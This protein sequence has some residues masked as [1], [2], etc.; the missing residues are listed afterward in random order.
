MVA[1][2]FLAHSLLHFG[3]DDILAGQFAGDFVR[4]SD[5]SQWLPG[6]ATGIRLHRYVDA[7]ADRHDATRALRRRF[8][9]HLRRVSGIAIDIAADYHL[10]QIW[11]SLFEDASHGSIQAHQ[12]RVDTVLAQRSAQL[13]PGLRRFAELMHQ[14]QLMKS[15]ATRDGVELALQRV[16]RRAPALAPLEACIPHIWQLDEPLTAY[17][18][19]LWPE[20]VVATRHRYQQLAVH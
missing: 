5:L 1:M 11:P 8:P 13:P 6:I 3:E 20:L 7:F 15:W 19:R 2:N 12:D 10:L 9:R 4:G 18:H 16:S 17:V 14:E